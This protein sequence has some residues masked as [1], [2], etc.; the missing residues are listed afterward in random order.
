MNKTFLIPA[1]EIASVVPLS[2]KQ[3]H[4]KKAAT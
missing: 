2:E 3:E 4:M 1:L